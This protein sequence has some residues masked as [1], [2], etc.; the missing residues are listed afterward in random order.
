MM[1]MAE[2]VH[3]VR[4]ARTRYHYDSYDDFWKLVELSRFA[5][6]FVDEIDLTSPTT[7]ITT[8]VNGELRPHV[9]HRRELL[10]GSPQRAKIIWWDLERPDAGGPSLGS[11]LDEIMP[12]VDAAWVSD[13]LV[14]SLDGRLQHVVLGGHAGLNSRH[15]EHDPEGKVLAAMTYALPFDYDFCHMSYAWGRR[16]N[17]FALLRQKGLREGPSCYG[18]AREKVLSSSRVLV[19]LQQYTL[20]V[21]APMRF[22]LAAAFYLPIVTERV[23]DPFPMSRDDLIEA[24]YSSIPNA[25]EEVLKDPV[26][27]AIQA[28]RVHERLCEEWTFRRGVREGL[29]R[30]SWEASTA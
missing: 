27:L 29:A 24:D 20:P 1:E 13:R 6:C 4:F 3:P 23:H 9:T 10:K 22:A 2:E 11:I 8:P 5:T 28:K 21:I 7:Y 12:F 16:E 26:R 30:L 19:N 15:I 17:I 25:I 14:A 18:E